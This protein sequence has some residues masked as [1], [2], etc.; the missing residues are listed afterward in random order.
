[1]VTTLCYKVIDL[2][3]HGD[4]WPA[5]MEHVLNHQ[6]QEGWELVTGFERTHEALQGGRFPIRQ[7]LEGLGGNLAPS[8]PAL[9]TTAG[10]VFPFK[11]PGRLITQG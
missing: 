6:A 3:P 11:L 5:S 8:Q 1:M 10:M 4:A 7:G 2:S 9:T